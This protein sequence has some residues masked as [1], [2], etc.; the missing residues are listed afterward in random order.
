VGAALG[1][2]DPKKDA[3]IPDLE[4]LRRTSFDDSR[5]KA[6]AYRKDHPVTDPQW[7]DRACEPGE[8]PPDWKQDRQLDL[9]RILAL[10]D[11][12]ALDAA[13]GI[14]G[15]EGP[16]PLLPGL[17]PERPVSASALEKLIECPLH[18]LFE[19]VLHW[20]EPDG[21]PSTRLLDALTYGSLLH[22]V[23]E[24]FY[25]A[26]GDD[27]VAR[28]GTLAAWKKKASA[29]AGQEFDALLATQPLVGRGVVEKERNRLL[30]DVDSFLSYDWR[31]PL[32]RF[33]GVEIPFDGIAIP[34][35]AGELHVHGRI[36]RLDVEGDHALLRDLKSGNDH[37]RIGKEA[38]PTPT[39]DVQLGL[40]SLVARKMAKQ[41]KIP[42][43][44]QAAYV[45]PR[46]SDERAF[47]DDHVEL[48]K[49]T[50]AW[51]GIAHGLLD[52]RAFP[53]S[54]SKEDCKFCPFRVTCDGQ[55]RAAAAEE[56][57]GAVADFFALKAG[58]EGDAT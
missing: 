57:E 1:R 19:R 44:L 29:I 21:S 31:L 58:P 30:R 25:V 55:E 17:S 39:R 26:H 16:F 6:D 42:A 56:A 22:A 43:K 5:K 8:V 46:R 50:K 32:D 41:W 11:R 49:A 33:V 47:R 7:L 36:D 10:R 23:A 54:P 15:D 13:D 40:Y 24:R 3:V 37:P 18:F 27:F 14:L 48:E 9:P 45:Y 20:S 35:G 28:K 4:S 52:A 12:E 38:G 2:P 51:L 34:A 53:P